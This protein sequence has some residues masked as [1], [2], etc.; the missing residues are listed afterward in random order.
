VIVK[1]TRGNCQGARI[2]PPTPFFW[3]NAFARSRSPSPNNFICLTKPGEQWGIGAVG[4]AE[5]SGVALS[6][7][8]AD[9][10]PTAGTV[11]PVFAGA[12][13]GH[14]A[15]AGRTIGFERS[16][17]GMRVQMMT[18]PQLTVLKKRLNSGGSPP[19]PA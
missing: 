19:G 14:V 2:L 12:D 7:L 6:D 5:W 3:D 11:E 8:L 17:P 4:T 18:V 1:H 15:A 16:L 9:A 10:A 13:A